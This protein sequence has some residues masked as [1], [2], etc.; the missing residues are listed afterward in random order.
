MFSLKENVKRLF[1]KKT[2]KHEKLYRCTLYTIF[3]FLFSSF[4]ALWF[5]FL[6]SVSVLWFNFVFLCVFSVG[7]AYFRFGICVSVFW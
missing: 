7:D 6:D 2:K 1:K 3:L 4:V 5:V